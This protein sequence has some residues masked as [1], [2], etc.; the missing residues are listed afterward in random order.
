MK[1][2]QATTPTVE[3]KILQSAQSELGG[4][5]EQALTLLA[6]GDSVAAE[7]LV[8]KATDSLKTKA[9]EALLQQAASDYT[10]RY[11]APKGSGAQPRSHKIRISNGQQISVTS[12][13]LRYGEAQQRRPFVQHLSLLGSYTLSLADKVGYAGVMS[14]SY[15]LGSQLLTKFGVQ[16]CTSSVRDITNRLAAQCE[17]AQE[18]N[19][20]LAEGESLAGK[21]VVISTDGGRA[22][23][24]SVVES[25]G[26]KRYKSYEPLWKEPKLF[27]IEVLDEKGQPSCYELP[28][29]GCRFS[30]DAMLDLLRDYLQRLHIDKAEQVQFIADGAV[31]IW[32]HIP[33][34]LKELGV[35][36]ERL[37]CTLDYYHAMQYAHSLVQSLPRRVDAAS[38]NALFK[39]IKQLIWKGKVS[40][41]V[42]LIKGHLQ[43]MNAD[44]RR[45]ITY[46]DKHKNH[47]QYAD[48]ECRKLMCGSGLMES[49][50]RR[51]INL[52]FKSNATFWSQEGLE[53]LFFLRGAALSKRWDMVIKNLQKCLT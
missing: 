9:M 31:W 27:V 48:L 35:R 30:K 13:Y 37:A 49:A 39:R 45:W 21:R 16:C 32:N 5:V 25:E 12:P 29:Y 23:V 14:G 43:R 40:K 28:I 1:Q 46:L 19:L 34:L 38:R 41:A 53:K 33:A 11:E 50:V 8:F 17:A 42:Q 47:M 52:R 36:A 10:E 15:D 3:A 51:L 24:R 4:I 20:L 44:Q 26:D 7:Q 18:P 22:R 2:K 6:Q